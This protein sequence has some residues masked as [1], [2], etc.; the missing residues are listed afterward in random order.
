[1]VQWRGVPI[2]ESTKKILAIITQDPLFEKMEPIFSRASR[3]FSEVPRMLSRSVCHS[4]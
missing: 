1:M 2:M 3:I 4:L